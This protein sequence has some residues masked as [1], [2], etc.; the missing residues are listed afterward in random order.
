M[1]W[2]GREGDL[3]E[4]KPDVAQCFA[5]ERKNLGMTRS[6]AGK[7]DCFGERISTGYSVMTKRT[8]EQGKNVILPEATLYLFLKS[9]DD[10]R[11]RQ[12]R[13]IRLES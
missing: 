3:L 11:C 4:S 10:D 5:P 12:Y 1:K 7:R 6:A 8:G 13:S 2:A 9:R